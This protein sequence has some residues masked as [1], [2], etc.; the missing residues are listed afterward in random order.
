[1]DTSL[2]SLTMQEIEDKKRKEPSYTVVF[3]I[4]TSE[5]IT[6]IAKYMST[7]PTVIKQIINQ[8]GGR[9]NPYALYEH[10]II[11]PMNDQTI[12]DTNINAL[13]LQC[14]SHIYGIGHGP[15]GD[16][17]IRFAIYLKVNNC[18]LE[19]YAIYN[20]NGINEIRGELVV[21]YDY[22]VVH[23]VQLSCGSILNWAFFARRDIS[24]K[25][26]LFMN[27]TIYK[28]NHKAWTT[29]D[30]Y[31]CQQITDGPSRALRLAQQ[32][33][34][35][36]EYNDRERSQL[37]HFLCYIFTENGIST[38]SQIK[39]IG[40]E[41]LTNLVWERSNTTYALIEYSLIREFAYR[42]RCDTILNITI[43]TIIICAILFN[44]FFI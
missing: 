34:R 27:G 19:S 3:T 33:L 18:V 13:V 4:E 30:R 28:D 16:V 7:I 15:N 43:I 24:L 8:F 12:D 10:I 41:S 2:R 17:C 20:G 32:L 14:P 35:H 26:V 29:V 39:K 1:M 21:P 31:K 44:L 40:I 36:V 22:N 23:M 6:I 5:D 38:W 37:A 25:L 9:F 11:K 42:R